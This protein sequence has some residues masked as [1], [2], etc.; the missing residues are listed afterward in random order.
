MGNARTVLLSYGDFTL[1]K[2][3]FHW[4][5]GILLPSVLGRENFLPSGQSQGH[6][7]PESQYE[8]NSAST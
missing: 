3:V 4:I 1:F 7:F 2:K 6:C 8:E 5:P